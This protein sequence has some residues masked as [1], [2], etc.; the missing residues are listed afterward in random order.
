VHT[1]GTGGIIVNFLQTLI[2]NVQKPQPQLH[3]GEAFTL[4]AVY[5]A[6]AETRSIC[7]VLLNHTENEDLRELI[8]HFIADVLEPQIKQVKQQML[9]EGVVLPNVT[10]DSPKADPMEIPAG[11]RFK[12][13]QI[14]NML[15]IKIQGLLL[16]IHE[17]LTRSLRDDLGAQYAVFQGHL[18]AQGATLKALLTQRGWL[19]IPPAFPG[20]SSQTPH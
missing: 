2:Q 1:L 16:F 19:R 15:V 20:K 5:E 8:E 10:P 18:L 3:A 14:A 17:G 12:D 7:L 4:W 9:N 13:E 11:A 6:S